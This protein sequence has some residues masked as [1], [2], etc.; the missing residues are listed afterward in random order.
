LFNVKVFN[1]QVNEIPNNLVQDRADISA[2]SSGAAAMYTMGGVSGMTPTIHG[3]SGKAA[4]MAAPSNPAI[5]ATKSEFV[6]NGNLILFGSPSVSF[7][8]LVI[9]ALS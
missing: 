6:S 5:H 4:L 9:G 8:F 3:L 2:Q 1:S 7:N